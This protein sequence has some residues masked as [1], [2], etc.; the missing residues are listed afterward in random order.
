MSKNREISWHEDGILQLSVDAPRELQHIYEG[1]AT[2]SLRL[3][4]DGTFEIRYGDCPARLRAAIAGHLK[5]LV[6][7]GKLNQIH[8]MRPRLV[9]IVGDPV[10]VEGKAGLIVV[11]RGLDHG[12]GLSIAEQR[13][14]INIPCYLAGAGVHSVRDIS[15]ILGPVFDSFIVG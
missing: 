3:L 4:P 12:D 15:P 10:P 7:R 11:P 2:F 13:K 14:H 5:L 9:G 8:L 1:G 6:G